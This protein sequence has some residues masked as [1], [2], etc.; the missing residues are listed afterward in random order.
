MVHVS[1]ERWRQGLIQIRVFRFARGHRMAQVADVYM[2]QE[3]DDSEVVVVFDQQNLRS[4][5]ASHD[6]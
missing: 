2:H 1:V 3:E 4:V 6:V 5:V